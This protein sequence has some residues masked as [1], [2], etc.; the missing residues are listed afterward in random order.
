MKKSKLSLIALFS[1]V[2]LLL[3]SCGGAIEVKYTA[4][5]TATESQTPG[6]VTDPPT[7]APALPEAH[8]YLT[9]AVSPKEIAALFGQGYSPE[10]SRWFPVM[11]IDNAEALNEFCAEAG[12]ILSLDYNASASFSS[13]I[14]EYDD[15]YFSEN[16]LAIGCFW[17]SDARY[18]YALTMYSK[19]GDRI[20][21]G[22]DDFSSYGD[23]AISGNLMV[24]ELPRTDI[25]GVETFEAYLNEPSGSLSAA[26]R[27][28]VV[29]I[30]FGG[31]HIFSGVYAR[32]LTEDLAALNYTEPQKT[33]PE[34]YSR[35]QIQTVNGSYVF[36]ISKGEV[37]QGDLSAKYSMG[38]ILKQIV[39][40]YPTTVADGSAG[41]T[42][43][44][45]NE[46]WDLLNGFAEP[47]VDGMKPVVRLDS[48]EE[49]TAFVATVDEEFRNAEDSSELDA[50][51][52]SK[53]E[54]FGEDYF[55]G[56]SLLLTC[57]YAGSGSYDYY[58]TDVRI[59]AEGA[60]TMRI[61]NETVLG[62]WVTDDVVY[63][64]VSVRVP[65][66]LLNGVGQYGA[67]VK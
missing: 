63:W 5:S 24:V 35:A 52:A 39:D 54:K 4:D 40:H 22:V 37:Y 12:K 17:S 19:V 2:M 16:A 28:A 66:N 56:Y 27:Q 30:R 21:F 8:F 20:T 67:T 3:S 42:Y 44:L 6:N 11:K 49:L 61:Y 59:D 47:T 33:N 15:A 46:D 23:D 1:V 62:M 32:K 31:T 41:P 48:W 65:T 10:L 13:A 50:F 53:I 7:D 60:L 26:D 45:S 55:D 64:A 25:E 57:F 58:L 29:E 36:V 18:H 51:I 34:T 38:S 9:G 43:Y 14:A